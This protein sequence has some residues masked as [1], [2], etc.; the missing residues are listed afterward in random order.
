MGCC[1]CGRY[2]LKYRFMRVTHRPQ[3]VMHSFVSPCVA[4]MQMGT[5]GHTCMTGS[6]GADCKGAISVPSGFDSASE[7]LG[8]RGEGAI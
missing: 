5:C 8:A 7:L 2:V 3:S 6:D 1:R 4:C